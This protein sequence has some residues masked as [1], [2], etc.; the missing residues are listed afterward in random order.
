MVEQFSDED[1]SAS[2]SEEE[3]L[4]AGEG[5]DDSEELLSEED[6]SE[7]QQQEGQAASAGQRPTAAHH[8]AA[9]PEQDA[10]L[11]GELSSEGAVLQLEVRMF[12]GP[13]S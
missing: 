10:L 8:A 3:S 1:V 6:G 13:V 5:S 2:G 9:L 4:D 12:A 11:A 7:D